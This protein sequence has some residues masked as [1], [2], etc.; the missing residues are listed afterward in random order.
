MP[1]WLQIS[2]SVAGALA[3]WRWVIRPLRRAYKALMQLLAQI[4]DASGGVNKLA[5]E[6]HGL[7]GAVTVFAF[8]NSERLDKVEV[9]LAVIEQLVTDQGLELVDALADIRRIR[10]GPK[11]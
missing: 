2:L 3:G 10:K 8:R 9:Q 5:L 6:L 7:A 1:H 11:Q 4:R